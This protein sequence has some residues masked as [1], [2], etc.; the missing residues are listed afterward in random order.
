MTESPEPDGDLDAISAQIRE[1][2]PGPE[3]RPDERRAALA[4]CN[5]WVDDW[6]T[7]VSA[8]DRLAQAQYSPGLRFSRQLEEFLDLTRWLAR[9]CET[10]GV[11]ST[12][13]VRFLHGAESCYHGVRG[14]LP[15]PSDVRV[16]LERLALRLQR[17]EGEPAK[18]ASAAQAQPEKNDVPPLSRRQYDILAALLLLNA[19]SP[20]K[21]RS[22]AEI[23]TK[24]EGIE[25]NPEG[26]KEPMAG[27]RALGL[28]ATKEGRGG[29]C[30]LTPKGKDLAKQISNRKQ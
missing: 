24:A 11:D 19:T 10:V 15:P 5:C 13:V 8:Q 29:G 26:F 12:P 18:A 21:R 6:A 3:P 16:V 9:W 27:L 28:I 20:D 23:T 30:W 1:Q 17:A 4:A 7:L 14:K 22:T 25:A 2:L